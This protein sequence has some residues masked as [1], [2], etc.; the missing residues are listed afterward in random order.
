MPC[1][2]YPLSWGQHFVPASP[3]PAGAALRNRPSVWPVLS[4]EHQ[5]TPGKVQ[6]S[7]L[8]LS[9]VHVVCLLL[10]C[11]VPPALQAAFSY[12]MVCVFSFLR[13][14]GRTAIHIH[15][16]TQHAR[17]NVCIALFYRFLNVFIVGNCPPPPRTDM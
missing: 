6:P 1:P 7:R 5:K 10:G 11:S 2:W 13:Q 3:A 8:L 16:E 12:K 4:L 14:K 17:Q 15:R 9:G